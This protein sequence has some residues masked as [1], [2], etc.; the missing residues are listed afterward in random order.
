LNGQIDVLSILRGLLKL[1]RRIIDFKSRKAIHPSSNTLFGSGLLATKV[2]K[3]YGEEI[4]YVRRT[5]RKR[6]TDSSLGRRW[7]MLSKINDGTS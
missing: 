3:K 2:I 1:L 7:N 4:Y 6:A 5:R